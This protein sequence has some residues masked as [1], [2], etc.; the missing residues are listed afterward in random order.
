M[1]KTLDSVEGAVLLF[2]SA[3]GVQAQSLSVY[4]KAKSIG[5]KRW[6]ASRRD[7]DVSADGEKGT[8]GD[9]QIF[10]VLTKVDMSS[11]RPLE[12]ALAVSDL[13]GFDP[14]TILKTSARARIGIKEV[15]SS[16]V[17]FVLALL[18]ICLSVRFCLR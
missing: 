13:F 9:I 8:E 3:Q 12:V 7:S 17:I 1:S 11:A 15:Y 10:P 14:D 16:P 6:M 5:R 2:D 18:T 4:D